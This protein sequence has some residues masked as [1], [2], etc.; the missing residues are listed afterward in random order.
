[1]S[2][3]LLTVSMLWGTETTAHINSVAA[4][5]QYTGGKV[6]SLL[7][8]WEQQLD[9]TMAAG[10]HHT[11]KVR[12]VLTRGS[13]PD[14][15]L[16]RL[17]ILCSDLCTPSSLNKHDNGLSARYHVQ[18]CK[19]ATTNATLWKPRQ[20]CCIV[21]SPLQQVS[22]HMQRT[23][24]CEEY[25]YLPIKEDSA[26]ADAWKCHHACIQSAKVLIC[27]EGRD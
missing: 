27:S 10:R 19:K 14:Q 18:I 16:H 9:R 21:F 1:M 23:T 13:Q 22:L 17:C 15:L 6:R 20:V 26:E 4:V 2:S 25:W 8:S 7:T 12:S 5:E 3:V 24:S 11:C